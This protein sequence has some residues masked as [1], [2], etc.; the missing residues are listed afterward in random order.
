[1]NQYPPAPSEAWSKTL[2]IS[3]RH[4]TP[5]TADILEGDGENIVIF[6]GL[7]DCGF[8]LWVP[9]EGLM[10]GEYNDDAPA[11]V[12]NLLKWARTNGADYLK[13]DRDAIVIEGIPTFE[14]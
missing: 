12:I 14:W 10:E 8:Y 13:L 2:A 11:E 4:I 9:E 6:R 7:F 1:M 5:K 3:I